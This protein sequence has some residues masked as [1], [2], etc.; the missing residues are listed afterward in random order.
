MTQT[1]VPNRIA[2]IDILRAITMVLMIFVND[3]LSLRDI[4]KWLMHVPRDYDGMGLADIVFPSFLFIVGMSIPFAVMNRRKKGDTDLQIAGHVIVRALALLV[5]GVFLVNGE[6]LNEKVTGISL[7]VWNSL[8]CLSFI[9]LWNSYPK[10]ANVWLIR[11][12]K[13]LAILILLFLA[14]IYQGGEGG[15][16]HGFSTYW[17]GILGL[18]GWAYLVSGLVFIFVRKKLFIII[19]VWAAFILL[20]VAKQ[21]GLIPANSLLSEIL[22]PIQSGAM[23][24]LTIGGMIISV[25]YLYYRGIGKQKTMLMVYAVIGIFL[26]VLGLYTRTLWELSKI[27]ATP[28]WVL[29]CSAITTFAFVVTYYVADVLGKANWFT[30]IRPAGTNTLLCYL[31]PYFSSAIIT[32]LHIN[33]PDVMLTG[34][35]GLF[36]SLVFSLLVVQIAGWLGKI[37]VQLKL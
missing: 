28:A 31:I 24:A 17:W 29:V 27:R 3:L 6:N 7:D 1:V 2:S 33:F 10:T 12:A 13:S 11:G 37:G 9:L 4:P 30:L 32:V 20:C 15:E 19:L 21:T 23:P 18:I 25:L 26:L 14:F 36:K 22:A 35:V 8:C 34:T 5:M 16:V